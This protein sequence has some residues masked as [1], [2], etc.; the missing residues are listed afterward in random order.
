MNLEL[1]EFDFFRVVRSFYNVDVTVYGLTINIL[2]I[3]LPYSLCFSSISI[4][5][6][7][8]ALTTHKIVGNV[9]AQKA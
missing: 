1:M 8:Y 7:T 4:L 3:I 2:K 5:N 9:G 6:V